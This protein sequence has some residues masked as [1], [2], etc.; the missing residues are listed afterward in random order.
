[1]KNVFTAILFA[2]ISLPAFSSSMKEIQAELLTLELQSAKLS[3]RNCYYAVAEGQR[4]AEEQK[5]YILQRICGATKD[6]DS[7]QFRN[8]TQHRDDEKELFWVCGE[9]NAKNALGVYAGYKKFASN[10]STLYNG[11]D[12]EIIKAAVIARYCP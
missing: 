3:A 11:P 5:K 8:V 2:V 1:M 7:V 12:Y 6:P 9:Y 4:T 10:V